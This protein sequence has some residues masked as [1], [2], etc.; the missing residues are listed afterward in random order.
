MKQKLPSY[1]DIR[2][3]G[4]KRIVLLLDLNVPMHGNTIV[5][6][7]RIE[8]SIP[9]L[10][11][12]SS[13]KAK[14]VVISHLGSDG[15]RSL[16]PIAHYLQKKKL[17]VRFVPRVTGDTVR[18]ALFSLAPGEILLLENIRVEA[19]EKKNDP[20]L[21]RELALYG[22]VF[23][24]DAFSVSHR[25]HASVV[26]IPEYLPAYAGPLFMKEVSELS[27]AI[28]PKHP[29][30]FI[31]CGA[32]FETKLPLLTK[33]LKK[34]DT[35]F[36][37]GA[38]ANNLIKL[39]G[40]E[41][42]RSLVDSEAKLPTSILRNKKLILPVDVIIE[43]GRTKSKEVIWKSDRIVDIGPKTV[44]YLGKLLSRAE[45][46]LWN[47]PLGVYEEGYDGATLHLL[48]LLAKTKATSIIGGGDTAAIVMK[49]HLEK[50]FTFVSTAGG[51]AL[52]FLAKETLPGIEALCK[53]NNFRFF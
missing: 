12:F 30:V 11:Y 45:L 14:I 13:R 31:L 34:A 35:V 18:E 20:V 26:G 36:V 33:Y 48:N 2:H 49:H 23:V 6:S 16:L 52:E 29:F 25:A 3:V 42:G 4:E 8:K 41:V 39:E 24:N 5:D 47:G 15:T 53:K 9:T 40:F 22:E 1:K 37:G 28:H 10:K 44:S 38:L 50:K 32:K 17:P 51:A 19:G 21:A 7:F 43:G 27:K 46:V